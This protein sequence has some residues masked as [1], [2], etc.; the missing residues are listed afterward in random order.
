[1]INKEKEAKSDS[2]TCKTVGR[3]S[4]AARN[5]LAHEELYS[6]LKNMPDREYINYLDAIKD[7]IEGNKI[8][9]FSAECF[10]KKIVKETFGG[11]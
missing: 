5:E 8:Y 7:F 11:N 2:P 1:L 9:P 6:Y 10:A 4:R 3:S